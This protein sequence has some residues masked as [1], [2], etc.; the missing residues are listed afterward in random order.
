MS[1]ITAHFTEEFN[2]ELFTAFQNMGGVFRSRVRRKT[3]V[4]GYRTHFPKIGL[5][6][7]ALPK[8]RK[9]KVPLMDIVRTRVSCDLTDLYGADM[10]D[11]MDELKTNVEERGAV[12]KAIAMSLARSEDD[13]A[14]DALATTTNANNSVGGADTEWTTDVIPRTVLEQ[15]GAAEAMDGGMM[16]ALIT[17]AAW[18]DALALNSFINSDYGGDPQLTV[19]GQRPKM[20]FGFAYAPYSRLPLHSSGNPLNMWWN[21][22]CV[23]VAVGKEITPETAWQADSDAWLIK[24][25]M[26]QGAVLIEAAGA[27][28]RRYAA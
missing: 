20:W 11:D 9:G 8:T 27:I 18:A 24:G 22:S 7:T 16:H 6:G 15:F 5:G 4:V 3:G 12:Q 14:R 21:Q 1:T 26:S 13:F 2:S 25:K 28:I 19:E 23:A 10:V 17:W